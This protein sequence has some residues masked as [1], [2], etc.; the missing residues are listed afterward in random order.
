MGSHTDCAYS[1]LHA[2]WCNI[3]YFRL[4]NAQLIYTVSH[5]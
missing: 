4:V 2:L 1:T 3:I 5:T